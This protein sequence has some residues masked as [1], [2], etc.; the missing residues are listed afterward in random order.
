MKKI[1]IKRYLDR[2]LSGNIG[3]QLLIF[4]LV[5]LIILILIAL[6]YWILGVGEGLFDAVEKCLADIFVGD[7]YAKY[8][9]QEKPYSN[10]GLWIKSVTILSC[11][12]GAVVV[13]GLLVA[14]LT[15]IIQGRVDKV[16]NGSVCYNFK[17]HYVVLGYN[18]YVPSL[19][20]GLADKGADVVVA[21]EKDVQ[22][23]KSELRSRVANSD[24]KRITV[25]QAN[26]T[27]ADDLTSLGTTN[28]RCIYIIGENGE[29]SHD[30]RNMQCYHTLMDGGTKVECYVY[31]EEQS[32]YDLQINCGV[33]DNKYYHPFNFDELWARKVLV[34]FDDKYEKLDYR[35]K[36]NN[37]SVHPEKQ[38]HLV[39]IGMTGIGEALIKGAAL[40]AHYPNFISH[41][42]RTRITCIDSR[43]GDL[44]QNFVGRHK[45]FF[46]HCNYTYK[47][48]DAWENEKTKKN[49]VPAENDFLDVEFEFIEAET[50]SPSVQNLIEAWSR[51][52]GQLLTIAFCE[53][54]D[55]LNFQW[56]HNLPEATYTH[57]IPVWVCQ[58]EV[59]DDDFKHTRFSHIQTFGS[60][61]IPVDTNAVEVQ[62]GKMVNHI[63]SLLYAEKDV[64]TGEA[65]QAD[66][67]EEWRALG[68]DKRWSNI[69]NASSF[70]Y[71]LRSIGLD[72]NSLEGGF[73][74]VLRKN[75]E[76]LSETEHNRWNSEQLLIGYRSTTEDEH[77]QI[78]AEPAKKKAFKKRFVH[79]DIRSYKEL[80]E[81]TKEKDRQ[82]II[83]LARVV[84]SGKD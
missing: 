51:D 64:T 29:S 42:V 10:P 20:A 44:M 65:F 49:E 9:Y 39:V 27:S 1:H 8:V 30:M 59:M 32:F 38:V 78:V 6:C 16:K 69:Y 54:D 73:E 71:K 79:D 21:V 34:D 83:N 33:G 60:Y 45:P 23:C 18:E 5:F 17:N 4:V 41:G 67:D 28:A 3:A 24:W 13:E 55:V 82:L 7:Q 50:P 57:G 56:S 47:Q 25:L 68:I 70:P 80:D 62:W 72:V 74:E 75:I 76:L 15:S 48:F 26:R 66:A 19:I 52:E 36:E 35:S 81:Y 12:V 77:R 53:K 2:L 11:I 63:Y 84:C 14:T 46:H 43:M 40:I 31:A 37:L 58:R 22:N 61:N